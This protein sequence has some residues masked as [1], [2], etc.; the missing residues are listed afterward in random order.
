MENKIIVF[1][2]VKGGV[3]KTTACGLFAN[4]LHENGY[5][6][7]VMDADFQATLLRKRKRELQADPDA[8]IPYEIIGLP[9]GSVDD[10]T[11]LMKNFKKYDGII[12]ID[13]PGNLNAENMVPIYQAADYAVIPL[14]YFDESIDATTIFVPTLRKISNCKMIFLPNKIAAGEGNKDEKAQ[15]EETMKILGKLGH[16]NKKIQRK[17]DLTRYSTLYPNSKEQTK[18]VKFAFEDIMNEIKY[19]EDRK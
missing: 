13:C 18:W 14:D 2:N 3:G 11:K 19:W 8:A 10:T 5:Q 17:I 6:V 12:L 15:R 4:W 7:A 16:L 9:S 1:A